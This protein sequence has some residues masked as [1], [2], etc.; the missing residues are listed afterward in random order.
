MPK[1]RPVVL[2]VED[3]FA[4]RELV[5]AYLADQD[6]QVIDA[7][8]GDAA[9]QIIESSG[10]IDILLTDIVMP[11]SRDG[12]AL[13]DEARRLWPAIKVLHISG[14]KDI[15]AERGADPRKTDLL[16][17]PFRQ[18][19]LLDRIGALLGRWAVDRSEILRNAYEYWLDA[20]GDRAMPD[21]RDID[22]TEITAILPHISIIEVVEAGAGSQFRFRLVGT[23]VVEAL[24]YD[25]TNQII[26]EC[27]ADGDRDFLRQLLLD[28][29]NAERPLYAASSFRSPNSG[30]STQRL[31]L[32]LTLAGRAVRQVMVVQTFEWVHRKRTIHDLAQEHAQRFD[33]VEYPP[34]APAKSDKPAADPHAVR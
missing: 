30:L 31:L 20:A 11:G 1:Q 25:P 12:F 22:P 17:K 13:A 4:I 21:R 5:R 26:D 19:E 14:H 27:G 23:R 16:A 18:A 24:G 2:I 6:Y 34:E 7:P 10:P 3:D 8:N 32:P 28:V 29:A 33:A 15:M 9:A